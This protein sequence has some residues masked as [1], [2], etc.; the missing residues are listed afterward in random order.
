MVG[1]LTDVSK[2]LQ[3]R[4]K[5][6]ALFACKNDSLSRI[7]KDERAIFQDNQRPNESQL[8]RSR[9]KASVLAAVR[10]GANHDA[11]WA[12]CAGGNDRAAAV[13]STAF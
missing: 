8:D 2:F 11:R 7:Y 4:K 12:C 6:A 1:I 10:R 3:A 5:Q 9:A 13:R